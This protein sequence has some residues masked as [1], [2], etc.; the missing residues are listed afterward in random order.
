MPLH[1]V[2]KAALN[3]IHERGDGGFVFVKGDECGYLFPSELTGH[4]EARESL[5]EMLTD[6][7][8]RLRIYVLEERDNALH[9]LSYTREQVAK[10]MIEVDKWTPPS[11]TAPTAPRIEEVDT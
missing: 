7:T 2:F 11:P 5:E 10:D 4:A 3:G 9:L 6:E 8:A 1:G